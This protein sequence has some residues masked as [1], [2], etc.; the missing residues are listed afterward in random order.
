MDRMYTLE[1]YK[2]AFD[3]IEKAEQIGKIGFVIKE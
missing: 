3:R 2:E 1:E